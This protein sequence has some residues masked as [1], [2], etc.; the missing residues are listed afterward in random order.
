MSFD[1]LSKGSGDKKQSFRESIY[2]WEIVRGL[3]VTAKH[4]IRNIL[5]TD[6]MPT[7]QY[8]EEK[9]V[10]GDRFRGRHHP[11]RSRLDS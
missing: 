9:R 2:L 6:Q 10:Y 7:M 5:H 1:G 8:P 4:L 3:G 11:I